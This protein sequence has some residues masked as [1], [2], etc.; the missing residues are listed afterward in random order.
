MND[1]FFHCVNYLQYEEIDKLI[2]KGISINTMNGFLLSQL[3]DFAS[4]YCIKHF[5]K[6]NLDIHAKINSAIR[7]MFSVKV[8][9]KTQCFFRR[10]GHINTPIIK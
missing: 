8:D 6:K 1:S 9:K 3:Y 5:V 2:K 4:L 10:K 7:D